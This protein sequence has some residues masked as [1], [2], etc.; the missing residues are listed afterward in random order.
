MKLISSKLKRP[1]PR[2]NYVHRHQLL[3]KLDELADYKVIVVQG[4]AGSGKTTLLS[5][6]FEERPKLKYRWLTLDEENHQLFSFWYYFIQA[7][8][9]E[10]GEASERLLSFFEV[11]PQ[12]NEIDNFLVLLTNEL[13]TC[14]EI[15]IVVDDF[16]FIEDPGLL[17]S[18]QFFIKYMPDTIHLILLTREYP[19]LYLGD[20]MMSGKYMEINEQELRFSQEESTYFLQQ[21]FGA[22]L[23]DP[24]NEK[25]YGITEGWIGGLQLITL[26]MGNRRDNLLD[27]ITGINKYMVDYLSNEILRSLSAEE[28]QFLIHTSILSYF[29]ESICNQL[30]EGRTA[31]DLIHKFTSKN[32]FII[33]IDE[34]EGIYRY[35]HLF[36][37][38]LRMKFND[39][40]DEAKL[41]LHQKAARISEM[42]GDVEESIKHYLQISDYPSMMN[43]ISKLGQSIQSWTYLQQ[44]PITALID[45]HD[46]LLQR[47]FYHYCNLDIDTCRQI[48]KSVETMGEKGA[49]WGIRQFSY[50]LFEEEMSNVHI[51]HEWMTGI[52][53]LAISDVTK[54]IIY[55]TSSVFLMIRDEYKDALVCLDKALRLER[56][57]HNPYVHF[58]IL[59][60]KSQLYEKLGNLK[61][62]ES[63]HEQLFHMN[64][65]YPYLSP[66]HVN[67][68]I[69]MAGIYL[70]TMRLDLAEQTLQKSK[71][72]LKPNNTPLER[73]YVYNLVEYYLL[74]GDREEALKQLHHLY[75]F[76]VYQNPLYYSSILRFQMIVDEVDE[77]L[78][79]SFV[80]IVEEQS[81]L[82]SLSTDDRLVYTKLL[83]RSGMSEKALEHVDEVLKQCRMRKMNAHLVEALL[84]KVMILDVDG[85]KHQR[86]ILH[87]LREAVHYSYEH[88]FAY[89]YMMQREIEG[90]SLNMLLLEKDKD[91]NAKEKAFIRMMLKFLEVEK[92]ESILSEREQEVLQVLARGLSNKDIGAVLSISIATVKTHIINIYSKLQVANRVEAAEKARHLGMLSD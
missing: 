50:F 47:F 63:L 2:K 68:L 44:V 16:H 7:I 8:K 92:S 56:D 11:L 67:T 87:L 46:L 36:Q 22:G 55:I 65:E 41:E 88:H 81:D 49:L 59:G 66:F 40:S 43:Q 85:G 48:I 38:F 71:H 24:L 18:I 61:D 45:N 27:Q 33:T 53:G 31:K 82:N 62:S 70:K 12:I 73:G 52:E 3:Q 72:L 58:F 75:E 89:P 91:L 13:D 83:F 90:K 6:F 23:D 86:E 21:T 4:T 78:M 34:Y 60:L 74:R 25:L 29:N 37:Q 69:G 28:E 39:L 54:A 20:L 84:V 1:A 9:A 79:S 15:T 57:F 32:L 51:N 14:S 17:Q 76:E 77:A 19:Q 80:Q 26:A 42:M 30:L 35:H 10:L 64:E 5:S